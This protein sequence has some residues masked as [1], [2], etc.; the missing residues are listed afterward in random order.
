M[1][2]TNKR[3]VLVSLVMSMT[4]GTIPPLLL[5]AGDISKDAL[6][7][8]IL[9]N[10]FGIMIFYAGM[11][12]GLV[13][14]LCVRDCA[15]YVVKLMPNL[16]YRLEDNKSVEPSTVVNTPLTENE[17]ITLV[18]YHFMMIFPLA[19]SSYLT[20]NLTNLNKFESSLVGSEVCI[21]GTLFLILLT[22][23]LQPYVC[24][25]CVYLASNITCCKRCLL[26]CADRPH[27]GAG[28]T[29]VV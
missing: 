22:K 3:W 20:Y 5:L 15:N 13:L 28:L 18:V 19:G 25:C 9:S 2:I 1:T 10:L 11:L 12:I 6:G 8:F 17:K 29:E 21:Y 27:T 16:H 4:H 23:F 26:S 14:Y 7:P 24:N